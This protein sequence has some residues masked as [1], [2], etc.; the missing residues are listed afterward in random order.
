LRY[1]TVIILI[2]HSLHN[3]EVTCL[4]E[5]KNEFWKEISEKEG[6]PEGHGIDEKM[7]HGRIVPG[8]SISKAGTQWQDVG[9][10]GRKW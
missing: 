10:R 1:T 7:K 2:Y 3:N 6:S 8:Y 5:S 4:S 9:V